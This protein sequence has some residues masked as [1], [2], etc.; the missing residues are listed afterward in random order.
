MRICLLLPEE[1]LTADAKKRLTAIESLEDLG[2]GF[3]LATHDLE[4]GGAGELLGDEQSGHIEEIGFSLYMELLDETV[5]ALKAGKE[6]SL[7]KPL[8][9]GIEVDL[10][11][12]ALIPQDYI[13]DVHTRLMLYQRI[14]NAKKQ[15]S[16]QDLQVEM[17]D[18]FG[19]L[20]QATKNLF[21]L[22]QVKLKAQPLGIRKISVTSDQGVIDFTSEPKIKTEV[23]ID[24]LQKYP[25]RYKLVG[26]EK[27]RFHLAGETLAERVKAVEELLEK[28]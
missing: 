1:A 11:A 24:L 25:Q 4:I 13:P 26:S 18:R 9:T 17:I 23:L 2:A 14:A 21:L 19:M 6:L 7:D 5:N 12:P 22:T 15:D 3:T 16:L 28:L 27:L 20:P 8:Q 10:Q